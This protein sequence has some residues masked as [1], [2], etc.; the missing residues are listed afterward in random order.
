L[1][2]HEP[3]GGG[4]AYREEIERRVPFHP[5]AGEN[6]RVGAKASDDIDRV[7]V[8]VAIRAAGGAERSE[9]FAASWME[10]L[11]VADAG[12]VVTS[13]G[14]LA[15]GQASGAAADPGW[16]AYVPAAQGEAYAYRFV[17]SGPAGVETTRWFSTKASTWVEVDSAVAALGSDRIVPGTAA[18]LTDGERVHRARFALAL[19]P[20]ER[21]TG[22]GERYER[23][24]QRGHVIDNRVFDQYT[25][26]DQTG[27]TY[28]PMPFA[29]V[30]GG[31]GW[32]FHV[33]TS[34]QTWFDVGAADSGQ[35]FVETELDVPDPGQAAPALE[36]AIYEGTPSQVLNAFLDETGRPEE[37]PEWTLRLWASSNEWNTQAEVERQLALHRETGIPIGALVI[38]AWSDESSFTVFRDAQYEV[39]VDGKPLRARDITYPSDGAWPDPKAMID[40]MHDE[41]VHVLL[42]QIPLLETRVEVA[43]AQIRA[44]AVDGERK[45]VM[46]QRP[47]ADGRLTTYAN[48]GYW[49]PGGLMPDLLNERARQ[50]WCEWRRY[51][52]EDLDVDGFKTDGGEHGWGPESVFLD[53]TSGTTSN[54][55]FPVGYAKAYG[56]LLRSAGKAPV[57]FSRAG[58]V[59]SQSHGIFWAG[60]EQSTWQA[61][62]SSMI[63]GLNASASGVLYWGWDI[64]G[65]SGEI[66]EAELYVRAFAASAF[67]PIMQYHSEYSFH[68]TPSRDRTPWNIAERRDDPSVLESIRSIVELRERLVPY[69]ATSARAS[70]ATGL[71]LMRPLWFVAPGEPE[72]WEHP[73]QWQLG[74]DLL[75]APVVEPGAS[76]W[77]IYLPSG[78]WIDAWSGTAHE[79]GSVTTIDVSDVTHLP[80]FVRASAWPQL[81][82]I[83]A[84]R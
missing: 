15:A 67:V 44:M 5:V 8:E 79:G 81:K 17:A 24:D 40:A 41:D 76:T 60:D 35:V 71:P 78:S 66:P 48:P 75:V 65:F 77:P 51:L 16:V 52:V 20:G 21:V 74:D 84:A 54:N 82:E 30:V 37:M 14:H 3:A 53:G 23:V 12:A 55:L 28:F 62:R 57:T 61:F 50:W 47:R 58:Y 64:A 29:H 83:F 46:V 39:S 70:V 7:D 43:N 18:Y 73:L 34:G 32:G 4:H 33:R 36:C 1:I 31:D 19:A 49:F 56:D 2:E 13:E 26:Q 11:E 68:R 38:E 69:L 59:G 6:F 9:T 27:R 63:A 10:R 22:F 45:G 80:V 25:G 42:W 72:A